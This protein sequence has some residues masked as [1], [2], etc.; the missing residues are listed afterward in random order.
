MSARKTDVSQS[1]VAK[2][3][4]SINRLWV[5]PLA[6][7]AVV[8]F[9]VIDEW[10]QPSYQAKAAR[11]WFEEVVASSSAFYERSE[12]LNAFCHLE[13]YAVPHL[14]RYVNGHTSRLDKAYGAFLS[15]LPNRLRAA[16]PAPRD[17]SYYY[18]RRFPALE[19][20]GYIGRLQRFKLETGE[21]I[22]KT[23][24]ASAVPSLRIALKD[25]NA[26]IRVFAVQ[27]L[28]FIGP[29]AGPVVPDLIKLAENPNERGAL[30]AV[31]A[32]GTV[33][34]A[35]SN[36][37]E[38]LTKIAIS[39]RADAG[40]A[41]ES[42]VSLGQTA[43]SAAP[44]LVP[45]LSHADE[46]MRTRAARAL[47]HFGITPDDAVPALV[48]LRQSTNTWLKTVATLAL[49]NRNL[50]DND[51][52]AELTSAL[53]SEMA[54]PL[55]WSIGHLPGKATAFL[56]EIQR[57]SNHTNADVRRIAT[58]ALRKILLNHP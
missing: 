36:A 15:M 55:A 51:F 23:S 40:A 7:L 25:G 29:P 27:T 10:L 35:A 16:L 22:V 6:G 12:V 41:V 5:I 3:K 44:A 8:M 13:G 30:G 17:D 9:L 26:D 49:W 4:R 46:R 53:E 42:I 45:L 21:P 38:L 31:Q 32:F 47:A 11:E 28:W 14:I 24:V 19:L 48:Q 18:S 1:D 34:P 2:H 43:R 56:P 57:L 33:G 20:L 50:S 58:N 52:K 54:G 39:G 37:V